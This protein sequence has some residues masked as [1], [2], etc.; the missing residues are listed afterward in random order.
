LLK[1]EVV[2]IDTDLISCGCELCVQCSM[3]WA[4]HQVGPAIFISC[5]RHQPDD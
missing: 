5:G 2:A 1:I 3:V 4:P